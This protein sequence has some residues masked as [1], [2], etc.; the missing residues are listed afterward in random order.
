[1]YF[2]KMTLQNFRQFKQKTTVM[3]SDDVNKNVTIIMGDNGTGKTSFAQAVT[4]CL[5]G[6]TDF[7]D[8][9]IFSKAKKA[10]MTPGDS[11]DTFVELVFTHGDLEYTLKRKVTYQMDFSGYIG[12]PFSADCF[13]TYKKED[14]QTETIKGDTKL[15][16]M[17]NGILPIELSRYFLFDG[18]RIE[19]MSGEI[20]SGKSDEFAEAVRRILGLDTY[21]QALIHLKGD[22]KKERGR[23]GKDTVLAKY[24]KQYSVVGNQ[25]VSRLTKE[26]DDLSEQAEKLKERLIELEDRKPLNQAEYDNIT[27]EIERNKNSEEIANKKKSAEQRMAKLR[28]TV[29]RSN[30]VVLKQFQSNAYDYFSQHLI[31]SAIDMLSETDIADKGVPSIDDKT[32]EYILSHHR[33]ICGQEIHENSAAACELRKLLDFIPPKSLNNMISSYINTSRIKVTGALDLYEF[34]GTQ[35]RNTV[36]YVE[37]IES[38]SDDIADYDA[39]LDGM[40]QIDKL[41]SKQKYYRDQIEKEEGEIRDISIKINELMTQV[42]TKE[43]QRKELSLQDESNKRIEMYRSYA[44]AVYSLIEQEYSVHETKVRKY[45]EE[46]INRIFLS[47]YS[48]GLALNIDTKYNVK[49]IVNDIK[50]LSDEVETSTA[51]SIS[52]VFA[53]I[54]GVIETAKKFEEEKEENK[55]VLSTEAYPLVMDAPLSSFDKKRIRTVCDTLP[56]ICEQVIIF[57]KDTDGEIAKEYLDNKVGRSYTFKKISSVETEIEEGF[58]V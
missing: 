27:G 34:T 30:S 51:Q 44:E 29:D 4:W 28:E 58:N 52:V 19:K 22:P 49:T 10:E 25:A 7:K 41:R 45:L 14:G 33:C 16:N 42:K 39:K 26:I 35:M 6:R 13:L 24:N 18:E 46:C 57:I 2:R 54:T 48:E 12:K 3:F 15:T 17:I 47:I 50:N 40:Q 31:A 55:R 21:L 32:I 1:M 36:Q 53:F 23:I 20:Q 5:Y 38:L 9:D 11:A 8:Q 56:G 37:E 43:A